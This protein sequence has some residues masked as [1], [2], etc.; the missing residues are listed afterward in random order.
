MTKFLEN[1]TLKSMRMRDKAEEL[2]TKLVDAP[3][4]PWFCLGM[5]LEGLGLGFEAMLRMP[6]FPI[7]DGLVGLG[8]A[9][10]IFYHQSKKAEEE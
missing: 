4:T 1:A 8:L 5:A 2:L 9:V 6:I 10:L 7:I 3:A